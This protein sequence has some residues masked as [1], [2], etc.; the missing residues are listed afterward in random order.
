MKIK[1][2]STDRLLKKYGQIIHDNI[3]HPK[4]THIVKEIRMRVWPKKGGK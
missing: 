2:A 4:T 3:D 1:K